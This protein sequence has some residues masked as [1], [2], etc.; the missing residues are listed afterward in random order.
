MIKLITKP[1]D[2]T[3]EP[4][5]ER[6]LQSEERVKRKLFTGSNDCFYAQKGGTANLLH[7]PSI[8][9]HININSTEV[10]AEST[11]IFNRCNVVDLKPFIN[12][13]S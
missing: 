8:A 11:R 1:L 10:G 9:V 12:C 5:V 7:S 3:F 2:L 6:Y 13:C 4:C